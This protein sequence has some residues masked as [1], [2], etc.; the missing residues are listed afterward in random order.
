MRNTFLGQTFLGFVSLLAGSAT[1]WAVTML[2]MNVPVAMVMFKFLVAAFI[3]FM[4]SA[5]IGALFFKREDEDS[6][7]V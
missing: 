2:L 4:F 5:L 6:H 1:I 7:G 3:I